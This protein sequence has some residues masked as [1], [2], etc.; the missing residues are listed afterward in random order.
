MSKAII[1]LKIGD[2][3]KLAFLDNVDSAS[4]AATIKSAIQGMVGDWKVVNVYISDTADDETGIVADNPD[5]NVF[6]QY[7]VKDTNNQ[8]LSFVNLPCTQ[9]AT[10]TDTERTAFKGIFDGADTIDTKMKF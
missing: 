2:S 6:N 5:D 10:I 3:S 8:V 4:D 9:S 7:I 1:K